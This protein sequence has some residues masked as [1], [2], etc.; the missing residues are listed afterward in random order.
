MAK[1]GPGISPA[2]SQRLQK[3]PVHFADSVDAVGSLELSV[4][5]AM[6]ADQR[7][8]RA[9][10]QGSEGGEPNCRPRKIVHKTKRLE[11][12]ERAMEIRAFALKL[13][14]EQGRWKT[15]F[16]G[17]EVLYFEDS[18]FLIMFHVK[19]AVPLELRERFQI[20]PLAWGLYGLEM[21]DRRIGKVL[22]IDWQTVG[23]VPRIVTFKRG[24]WEQWL[25]F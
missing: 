20:G 1:L 2:F 21:W 25:L 3:E 4:T 14:G 17:P 10:R 24:D 8:A 9:D 19:Q 11:R 13:L 16:Y 15:L 12:V 18:R 23:A 6:A 5:A 22:N 7:R